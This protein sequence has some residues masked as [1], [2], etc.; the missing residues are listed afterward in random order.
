MK[1]RLIML[2]AFVPLCCSLGS[3][4]AGK[5]SVYSRLQDENPQ[6]R[7]RACVDAGNAGDRKA[8]ALLVERLADTED[9]VRVFAILALQKITGQSMGYRHFDTPAVR[10]QAIERWRK[11]LESEASSAAKA[12]D[13][14]PAT[15]PGQGG[16]QR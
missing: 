10:R 3:C 7:V 8:A 9:D 5:P 6:V 14:A 12:F 2:A 15:R 11:Y 16:G 1:F 13:E 4:S